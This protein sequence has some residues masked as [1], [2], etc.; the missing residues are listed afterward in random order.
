MKKILITGSNSYVGNSFEKWLSQWPVEYSINS[1]GLR[2]DDWREN[3]FSQYDVVYHLA[4]IVHVKENDTEKY[5]EVNRD[6]ACD[7]AKKA[8]ESG[9]K[10]FI[11]MSTMGVYGKETGYIKSD[12]IPTPKTPYARSKLEAEKLILE[13]A[14]NHFKVAVLRP[15][16]IYGKDCKGNY[17]RLAKMALKLPF[18]PNVRNERSMLHIDNLCE[19]VRVVIDKQDSGLFFP[20][21]NEYVNTSEMVKLIAEMHGKRIHLTSIF[22]GVLKML[23]SKMDLVNKVFGNLVYEKSMSDYKVN[24]QIRGFKESIVLTEKEDEK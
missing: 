11:F 1:V 20:Q 22:N 14:D 4:A 8:K 16:I 2:G 9:V 5:F 17:P 19:F 10:Q 23:G 24:Y 7:V 13:I 3:D 18:F 12:T 21:N 15:P 6:L